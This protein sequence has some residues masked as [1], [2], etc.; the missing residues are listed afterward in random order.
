VRCGAGQPG[1]VHVSGVTAA[2]LDPR[3]F[4]LEPAQP[5]GTVQSRM[6]ATPGLCLRMLALVDIRLASVEIQCLVLEECT[7]AL[8]SSEC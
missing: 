7:H 3:Y 4:A 6:P 5:E 2:L 8:R 1:R